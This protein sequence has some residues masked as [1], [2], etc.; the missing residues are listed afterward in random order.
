MRFKVY[1]LYSK[2]I[3]SLLLLLGFTP[4][5]SEA[6]GGSSSIAEYGVPSA[7]FRVRG[8]LVDKSDDS[9]VIS[10]VKVAIGHPYLGI[11]ESKRT[12]YVDS[13]V[14]NN[15]GEFNL[16]ISDFPRSQKFVIKYEDT[17]AAQN[18]DYGLI[19]DTVRFE[20]PSFTGER[21]N[22]S[23]GETTKDLDKVKLSPTTDKK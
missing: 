9:K 21:A 6:G 5:S 11:S 23:V 8:V 17:D 4:C 13:I 18:G 2:I 1:S 20:N 15:A 7:T 16:S 22:W 10:G 19:I 14:T 3:S 12:F